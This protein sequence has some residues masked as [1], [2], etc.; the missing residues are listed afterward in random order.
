MSK[1]IIT[2]VA[3][4]AHIL[5]E[6]YRAL[7]EK[8]PHG[9]S[10]GIK[11]LGSFKEITEEHPHCAGCG[12]SLGVRL[13][14]AALPAPEDTLVVGTP[15]C[16]FFALSQTAVNYSNT[17][18]GN[19][20][21]VA[22]GLKR[23]LS[24]RYPDKDKDVVVMAGDGGIADIGLDMTLHSWFRGEKISTIMLDNEVYGNTGG[25]ES[26][27]SPEGQVLHMAPKGK[28]FK[29]IPVFE[30]ARTAGCV[31]GAKVTIA[32][33]KRLGMA[34]NRAI[35]LAREL[36]PT[37]VQI[38][39]PCPTNMK[40]SPADTLRIAKEAGKAHY[41]FEEFMTEEAALRIA[42]M[43]GGLEKEPE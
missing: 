21:S 1:K 34:V 25:Q 32:S 2:P 41:A 16:S 23:M 19:Q 6:D 8:G 14:L 4:L 26:G 39:T 43:E 29:K 5:P 35:L 31:Y 37:Y 7:V 30:M 17:A 40:F 18:F 33:P 15:G 22:S 3:S 36:G 9:K 38:Y 12:V 13:A 28:N 27:M 24:I 10:V 11:D 20:N 42:A